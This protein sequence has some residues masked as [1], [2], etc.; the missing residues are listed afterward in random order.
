MGQ[1]ETVEV[2]LD[3]FVN[4]F[5]ATPMVAMLPVIII[6]F[7][8]GFWARVLY[9]TALSV[10]SVLINPL[11]GIKNV[12]RGFVD[13]GRAFGLSRRQAIWKIFVPGPYI[14]AGTRI[15]LGRGIIAMIIAEMEVRLAGLGGLVQEYGGAFQTS[16]LL[17]VVFA[18]SVFGVFCVGGLK[19]IER[20][21]FPWIAG[22][23]GR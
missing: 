8:I 20:K 23:A 19:L 10:F 1:F 15:A 16:N 4:F 14:L 5:N 3:P 7:G 22:I 17:A 11:A 6:W 18:T 12:Q 2:M 21:W 9:V 13:V